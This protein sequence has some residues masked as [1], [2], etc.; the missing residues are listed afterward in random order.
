MVSPPRLSPS[1]DLIHRVTEAALAYTIARMR[2]IEGIPG[3]PIG[4]RFRRLD[5]GMALMAQ[6]LPS[7]S[8]NSVVGLRRGQAD[9]IQP[10]VEWYREHGVAGGFEIS[11]GDNDPAFARELTRLG[12]VQSAFHA[13]LIGEPDLDVSSQSDAAV[14]LVTS[15]EQMEA[16]LAAYVEGWAIPAAA[17]EEFKRNVRPWLGQPGW[18]LYLARGDGRAAATAILFIREG[19]GYFADSATDPAFRNRG[20][21][22]AL[23]RRRA[24][25]ARAAGVDFVCAGAD[26]L[27]TSHRNMERAGMRLLFLRSCWT[28]SG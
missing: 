6:D 18:F 4:V 9:C 10:L 17:R 2:V 15:P 20:L 3:N 5:H 25:D 1:L 22:L 27:S 16:F 21:H 19:V 26:F 14:E 7:A 23:L 11:S 28:P 13:A 12:F 24:K 8:F